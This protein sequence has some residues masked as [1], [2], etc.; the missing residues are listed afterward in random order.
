LEENSWF[1]D[2]AW[3]EEVTNVLLL[4]G[5]PGRPSFREGQEQESQGYE[6]IFGAVT[7]AVRSELSRPSYGGFYPTTRHSPSHSCSSLIED[8]SEEDEEQDDDDDDDDLPG[9]WQE[10]YDALVIFKRIHG[11]C[12]VQQK[13]SSSVS[14]P[15]LWALSHW[16]KR[17]RFS[18]KRRRYST[19]NN[20]KDCFKSEREQ[21][22]TQLGFVWDIRGNVWDNRLDELRAFVLQFGHADVP[23][24]F[25]PNPG[26]GLWVKGQ[27][28]KYKHYDLQAQQ[29]NRTTTATRTSLA[30]DRIAQ[31]DS[32]G[33]VWNPQRGRK[34]K[35]NS[36]NAVDQTR[37]G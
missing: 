8:S 31:L 23:L 2:W 22:L 14:D 29:S 32:L 25:T 1:D 17:Q 16:V 18:Y 15:T 11:H 9:T 20:K 13:P 36:K 27:R 24:Q 3:R 4:W 10:K 30:S 21:I 37:S 34:K 19:N 28:Q 6:T 26:L 35:P 5:S 12:N 33:M 7:K